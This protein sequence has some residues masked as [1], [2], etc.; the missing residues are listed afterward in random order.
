MLHWEDY[1]NVRAGETGRPVFVTFEHDF[2]STS[3][4]KIK[5]PGFRIGASKAPDAHKAGIALT[6]ISGLVSFLN[7]SKF[8]NNDVLFYGQNNPRK[9]TLRTAHYSSMKDLLTE[10]EKQESE[11]SF[12]VDFLGFVTHK[13]ADVVALPVS[14]HGEH[15]PDNLAYKLGYDYEE[16]ELRSRGTDNEW[17]CVIIQANAQ[18]QGLGDIFTPITDALVTCQ[19]TIATEETGQVIADVPIASFRSRTV[20]SYRQEPWYRPVQRQPR[21]D[22]ITLELTDRLGRKIRFGAGIPAAIVSLIHL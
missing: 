14:C 13:S 8:N 2:G 4:T 12:E 9:V 22:T 16:G 15:I 17:K 11:M 19:E 1:Y 20:F 21:F 18:A 6:Q 5:S 7:V 10:M 3:I